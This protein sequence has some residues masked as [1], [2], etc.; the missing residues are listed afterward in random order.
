M[1]ITRTLSLLPQPITRASVA[2]IVICRRVTVV[3]GLCSMRCRSRV[4][5]FACGGGNFH[6]LSREEW[7]G[8][9]R[10]VTYTPLTQMKSSEERVSDESCKVTAD[11]K[12]VKAIYSVK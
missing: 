8:E 4:V 5:V 2:S 1:E 12:H 6:K 3:D 11:R 10:Q 9:C 7:T